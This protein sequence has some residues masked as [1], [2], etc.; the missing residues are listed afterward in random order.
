MKGKVQDQRGNPLPGVSVKV[1]G[2]SLG[3]STDVN[4]NYAITVPEGSHRLI[5]SFIGFT[6]QTIAVDGR[7]TVDVVLKE[8]MTSLNEV[9]VVGY[10]TQ[11]KKDLTGAVAIVNVEEMT[12]QPSPS[13]SNLLQGQASGVTILGSG[14]PG[15]QPQI[16]IRGINTFGNNSPLYVID[17]VPTQ[18]VSDINPNDIASIQVMKDAGSASIYGSRAANGVI[19][20]TTKRGSGE[21]KVQ[22]DAYYGSQRPK[23]GKVWDILSPQEMANLKL[24]ARK[25]SGEPLKDDLYG[26]GP[27][28]TLPDYIAPEGLK[29]GDPRTDPSRYY[30]NPL[31]TTAAEYNSF[32]RITKANKAGTDWYHEIFRPAPITSHNLSVNGGTEKATYMFSA[33]YFNQEGTLLETYMKRYSIRANTSYTIKKNIRIGENLEYSIM[34]NPTIAGLSADNAIGHAFREQPI[35]PV[36]DIMGNYG[37]SYGGSLGDAYNP[38]A[39]LRRTANNKTQD[40]RLFGNVYAEADILKIFTLRTSFG[41]ETYSGHSRAFTFPQYENAEN[42]TQ[43]AYSENSYDGFN[44]TWTNTLS[45]N[46]T[47]GQHNVK[48]VVGTEFYKNRHNNID[49]TRRNYFSFDPN[50]TTLGTGDPSGMFVSSDRSADALFSVIGRLDYNLGEKYLLGATLRRDGSSKFLENTYGWFPSFS[51]AWRISQERFMKDISW[52]TD[53]KIRG[54]WGIMGNQLNVSPFNSFSTFSSSVGQSFYAINGGNAVA[55]GFYNN[56]LGNPAAKWEKD[57]NAN[58][59]FDASFLKGKLEVTA[60]YYRKDIKDLLYAPEL[61]ATNGA[62]AVPYQNVAQM[63]NDGIDA[64]VTARTDIAKDLKL[65]ATATVTTYKNKI[66][67]VSSAANY[68]DQ[69]SRRFDGSSIVRNQVGHSVSEFYGYQVAGFWDSQ[70]E[71]DEANAMA[72]QQTGDASAEY[73]TDMGLGRFRYADINGDGRI[74]STDRTFIGN[75][76]PDFN[77]GLNLNLS[78][79]GFDLS[80]FFYGVHGNQVWNQVKWWTDFYPSFNGAKSRTALYNSWTPDNHNAKAPIQETTN[81]FSTNAVPSSY[82]VENGSYLRLK[83]AQLGYNLPASVLRKFGVNRLRLYLSAANLFTITKYSGVDPEIG[84]SSATGA[85]TVYGVDDGSYP[86]QRTFL[87]GLNLGF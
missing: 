4:G 40:N 81:S 6:A 80:M 69:D 60:D 24:A 68:F 31:F 28:Y 11:K 85:E 48:M 2:S 73:Q 83:N 76:N 55:M 58:F 32:Y 71:M 87:F 78:Y 51:A 14:Q 10:S 33:N 86:S 46:Q 34:D 18:N 21:P 26:A 9:V 8:E 19:I 16:K 39:M 38:V 13:V 15:E 36:Y 79:K 59:G 3:V 67:K 12:K 27:E 7:S 74:T 20:M 41:G 49:G 22:Y 65:T 64:S 82:F 29:E 17:G 77:Y 35:I 54:G 66:V 53:F 84:T 62:A 57:V 63:K 70:Q 61:L 72:R 30:L 5:F 47:F 25:N 37:G 42:T 52:L 56:Q 50:Y 75:A 45:F 43:N 23:G 1:E 44:Y